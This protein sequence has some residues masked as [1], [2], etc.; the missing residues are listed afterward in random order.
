MSN[1]KRIRCWWNGCEPHPQDAAPHDQ[2]YC[3]H[4][5]EWLDYETFCGLSGMKARL[6]DMLGWIKWW[7]FRKWYPEKCGDCGKRYGKHD[8]CLPF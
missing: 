2:L 4:C 8:Q 7:T 5:G 3:M 6:F 1:H